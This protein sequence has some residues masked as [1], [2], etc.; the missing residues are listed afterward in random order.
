MYQ[1]Q[2]VV[3]AKGCSCLIHD[4]LMNCLFFNGLVRWNNYGQVYREKTLGIRF[5]CL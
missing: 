2:V 1:A 5:L 4:A 3:L